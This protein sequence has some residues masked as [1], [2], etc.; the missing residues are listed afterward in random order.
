MVELVEEAGVLASEL[1]QHLHNCQHHMPCKI[2]SHQLTMVDMPVMRD[3]L[4]DD[5]RSDLWLRRWW[6]WWRRWRELWGWRALFHTA[7]H[8]LILDDFALARPS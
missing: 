4:L 5:R 6:W 7:N 1:S 2:I 8:Y 3:D